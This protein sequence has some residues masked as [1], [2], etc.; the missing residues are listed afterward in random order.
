MVN[1]GIYFAEVLSSP[2]T[3]EEVVR[4]EL[5]ESSMV[6]MICQMNF[7]LVGVGFQGLPFLQ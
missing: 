2:K 3:K 4:V 5:E 1:P 7:C 6:G